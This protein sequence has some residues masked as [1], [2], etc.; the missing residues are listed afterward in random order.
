[1]KKHI[2]FTTLF[3]L[4]FV[5]ISMSSRVKEYEPKFKNRSWTFCCN[6]SSHKTLTN[7]ACVVTARK[8]KD[9]KSCN[10]KVKSHKKAFPNHG[11][12]CY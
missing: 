6:H 8:Y 5:L 2:I 1:M 4:S 10:N 11:C 7:S 3:L 12:G 9:Y